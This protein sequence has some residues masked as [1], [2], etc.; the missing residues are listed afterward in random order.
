VIAANLPDAVVLEQNRKI[1]DHGG[2]RKERPNLAHGVNDDLAIARLV[3]H[4]AREGILARAGSRI[5]EGRIERARGRQ[6]LAMTANATLNDGDINVGLEIGAELGEILRR[7]TGPVFL[8]CAID[9]TLR[10]TW[11]EQRGRTVRHKGERIPV[12]AVVAQ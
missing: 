7:G 6:H 8:Q 5:T 11:I 9:D 2:R 12:R 3:G 1:A 10:Q 4:G